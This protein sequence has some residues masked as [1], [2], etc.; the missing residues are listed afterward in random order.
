MEDVQI[1]DF[2]P[3]ITESGL[4]WTIPISADTIKVNFAAG[5]A[6]F[7]VS[8]VDVED[9]HDVVNALMDGP[10]VDAEVSWNIRWSHPL[11]RTKIRDVENNF[12]GDFVQNVGC[13]PTSGTECS[14][15]RR[16]KSEASRNAWVLGSLLF[17]G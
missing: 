9:Y 8:D 13:W 4:F 12:A 6:S 10:E 1:H 2:N 15:H 3:G 7:Q 16:K 17:L 14:S 5:K 11:G